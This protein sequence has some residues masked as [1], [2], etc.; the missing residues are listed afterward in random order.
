MMI[1]HRAWCGACKRLKPLVAAS[2][3]VQKLSENF[4]WSTQWKSQMKIFTNQMADIF[5]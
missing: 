4:I 5:Q 1:I 2:E 3:E